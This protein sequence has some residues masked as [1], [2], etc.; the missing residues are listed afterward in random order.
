MNLVH[1]KMSSPIGDLFLVASEKGLKSLFWKKTAGIS[2]AKNLDLQKA[3]DKVLKQT[4][5]ELQKYFEGT[6][7]KF[8]VP[9][10]TEGTDFQK[11][12]WAQLL[13]IPY[14]KTVSYTETARRIKKDKAVRAVGT[15]NGKNPIC[16]IIPCHRVIAA[17][18]GLGGYSGGL[19][20]KEYLLRQEAQNRQT[21]GLF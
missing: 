9:L 2:L 14:G 8:T 6:L 18:G 12:V 17:D 19:Q 15:A 10:D 11:E 20:R 4:H 16:I 5:D 7:Q 3:P 1:W 13:K 21:N